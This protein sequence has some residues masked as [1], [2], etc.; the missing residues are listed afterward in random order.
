MKRNRVLFLLFSLLAACLPRPGGQSPPAAPFADSPARPWSYADL[1]AL[2]PASSSEE[3]KPSQDLIAAYTRSAGGD[4]QIRLDLLDLPMEADSDIYIALDLLPGG[5]QALPLEESASIEWD[6]LL[7]LPAAS[8][9]QAYAPPPASPKAAIQ[10]GKD[11]ASP[12]SSSAV[13][14]GLP[15][16]PVVPRLLRDPWLDAIVVS[17]NRTM[18]PAS[19]LGFRM[20]AFVTPADSARPSD[21]LGPLRSDSPPPGRAP[22]LLAFWN[23]L[24]AYSPAQA[25]R[26]W[27]GAHTGP[28]GERHGLRLLLQAARRSRLPVAL[29][30]LKNPFS[31]SALDFLGG[32]EEVRQLA[33]QQ[34]LI[35]PEALPGT[36]DLPPSAASLPDWAL[37]RALAE[38]RQ[39]SLDFGLGASQMLFAPSLE[40]ARRALSSQAQEAGGGLPQP[41]YRVIFYPDSAAT[42][43][44]AQE[45]AQAPVAG[46]PAPATIWRWQGT[47][48]VALPLPT[49]DPQATPQGPTLA[50]RRAL[51]VAALEGG[52]PPRAPYLL[53]GDL[54][55]SAWGDAQA[56]AATL[57]YLA[58]HPWIQVLDSASLNAWLPALAAQASLPALQPAPPTA[59]LAQPTLRRPLAAAANALPGL[60]TLQPIPL[61]SDEGETDILPETGVNPALV[62]LL[63]RLLASPQYANDASLAAWQAYL[64]LFAASSPSPPILPELRA[65]YTGQIGVLME[66]ASWAARPSPHAD[67][68]SDP[69]LDGIANCILASERFFSIYDSHGGRLLALFA[70]A[71]DGIH[72]I[73]APTTQFFAGLGDPSTWELSLAEGADPAGVHGAFAD[74]APPW[75][76]YK[77]ALYENR[78]TFTAPGSRLAKTYSLTPHGLRLEYRTAGDSLTVQLP[79]AIDGWRRFSP[80]WGDLYQAESAPQAWVWQLAGGPRVEVRT[81]AELAAHPFTASRPYLR[82]AEDPN[83]EY[84]AGHYLPFPVALVE[85]R[86][87]HNFEVELIL[88]ETPK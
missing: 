14:Q 46:G 57:G 1:R 21:R 33:S 25:L 13:A 44:V 20:Q 41:D 70:S 40:I 9:P 79:L 16:S 76:L 12:A 5:S 54:P 28:F 86:S 52:D 59:A 34:L 27:D 77:A 18:L 63:A 84:P 61:F 62:E 74:G 47:C 69:D 64:S 38:S 11:G 65:L 19:G 68:H 67:C 87:S 23:A 53:G 37:A 15:L 75:P 55:N 36:P 8:P 26:R 85:M 50:V 48:L 6:L 80:N 7:A 31:L 49:E 78:L 43:G 66:A 83:R 22:V 39:A 58:D 4:L 71:A 29:L 73:V 72:Q 24:P 17:L 81:S 56:A 60:H 42:N 30:D 2:A 3:T 45:I 51:L 88:S 10:P 82:L 32:L 35:L